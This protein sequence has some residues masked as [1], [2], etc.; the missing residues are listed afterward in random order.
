MSDRPALLGAGI[1][2]GFTMDQKRAG[3]NKQTQALPSGW[4]SQQKCA[5]DLSESPSLDFSSVGLNPGGNV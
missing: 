4:N 3:E 1:N 5:T 2:T